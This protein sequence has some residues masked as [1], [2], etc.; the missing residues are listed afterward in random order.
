[1]TRTPSNSCEGHDFGVLVFLPGCLLLG[2]FTF[3][4][5][6]LAYSLEVLSWLLI[7]FHVLSFQFLPCPF[8]FLLLFILSSLTF[9]CC[10]NFHTVNHRLPCPFI[11]HIRP[12]SL[13]FPLSDLLSLPI[14]FHF[15]VAYVLIFSHFLVCSLLADSLSSQL[16][17]V[18]LLP[19]QFLST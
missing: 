1:M 9:L 8:M 17:F 16:C 6:P 15:V 13:L 4:K 11:V 19:L 2:V 12:P 14:F 7:S 5:I 10:L 18:L 3:Y